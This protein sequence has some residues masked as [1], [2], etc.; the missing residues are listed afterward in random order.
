MNRLD[1]NNSNRYIHVLSI[2][3]LSHA[4]YILFV[5]FVHQYLHSQ[6]T[7]ILNFYECYKYYLQD[8][9]NIVIY[10]HFIC[11]MIIIL[12]DGIIKYQFNIITDDMNLSFVG[13]CTCTCVSN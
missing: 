3:K 13:A 2:L 5:H 6:C 1:M 10:Y 9:I 11:D 4:K 12:L 8:R 7:L